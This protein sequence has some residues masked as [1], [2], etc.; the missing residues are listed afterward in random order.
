MVIHNLNI[1]VKATRQDLMLRA[2]LA[3]KQ[4][5][6]DSSFVG[7]FPVDW[8]YAKTIGL[9]FFYERQELGAIREVKKEVVQSGIDLRFPFFVETDGACAGNQ[10]NKSAGGWGAV[11]VHRQ[12]YCTLWGPKADTSNNGTSSDGFGTG[13]HPGEGLRVY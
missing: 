1:P 12:Q 13:D 4:H 5:E 10:E 2:T 6:I 8:A 9:T 3:L 11:V 7:I